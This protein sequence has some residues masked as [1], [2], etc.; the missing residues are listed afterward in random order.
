MQDFRFLSEV[1]QQIQLTVSFRDKL[2]DGSE[3]ALKERTIQENFVVYEGAWNDI[4]LSVM[5]KQTDD[6]LIKM[7]AQ[8]KSEQPFHCD[9]IALRYLYCKPRADFSQCFV[10]G[11]NMGCGIAGLKQL[12][13]TPVT[14]EDV[15]FCGLFHSSMEPCLLFGTVIPSNMI[16]KY[17]AELEAKDR[18]LFTATNYFTSSRSDQYYLLTETICIIT[19][20]TPAA[21]VIRYGQLLPEIPAEKFADPLIGWSTWDYYFTAI[22]PEDVEENMAVIREN[23]ELSEKIKYIFVDDGWQYREGEWFANYRFPMGTKGIA[24]AIYQKGFKP[25]IWTNGC[26]VWFLTHTGLRYSEMMLKDEQGN[27][28]TFEERLV[29]DPTHPMGEKF[30]YETYRRLREDGF[31]MFKVDFVSSILLAEEFYDPTC[32]PYGA[33]RKLFSIIRRAVGEES[34]IIGC[35]YPSDS[36]PG[37]V[38]SCRF[39]VDIHNQ[40]EHVLWILEYMQLSFWENQRL[41][42][43]DPDFLVVRGSETSLEEETNV[44]NPTPNLPF[45]ENASTNRWRKGPVFDA[46]EAETWAN[47]VVFCAGNIILG[48]RISKLN[49]LGMQLVLEHLNPNKATAVPLDL[50]DEAHASVWYSMED[51]K[52]LLINTKDT[53]DE[54]IVDLSRFAISVPA[55]LCCNKTFVYENGI[56]RCML[57]KHESA[58]FQWQ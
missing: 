44:F 42:R 4:A 31:K 32:G 39:A 19:G 40:W 7:N 3:F 25:G 16:L 26:Q 57:Q 43:L 30:I 18:V 48:D 35:S 28:I 1:F 17:Q 27:A 55:E 33:I 22:N 38:E 29:I 11:G 36:G 49:P 21:A 56:I 50:G 45:E 13:T 54:K 47:L 53:P 6:N 24:D 58:V 8:L 41:Y 34:Q 52:L 37:M 15:R 23:P 14:P 51:R 20:L 10:P 12:K 46:N 2:V 5:V 9:K